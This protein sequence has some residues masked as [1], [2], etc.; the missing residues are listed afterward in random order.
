VKIIREKSIRMSCVFMLVMFM[1]VGFGLPCWWSTNSL[2]AAER[3]VSSETAATVRDINAL[4]AQLEEL[5]QLTESFAQKQKQLTA[6]NGARLDSLNRETVASSA[7]RDKDIVT[8]AQVANTKSSPGQGSPVVTEAKIEAPIVVT[9]VSNRDK[10]KSLPV[11]AGTGTVPVDPTVIPAATQGEAASVETPAIA[12]PGKAMDYWNADINKQTIEQMRE[13]QVIDALYKESKKIQMKQDRP[14]E[15]NPEVAPP[16]QTPVEILRALVKPEYLSKTMDL[17]FDETTLSDIILLVSEAAHINVVLDPAIKNDKLDLHLNKIPVEE[18]LLLLANSYNLGFKAVGDSLYITTEEKLRAQNIVSR[19]IRLKN[20]KAGE[21]KAMIKDIVPTIN[22]SDE[23][24]SVTIVGQPEDIITV[25]KIIRK[26]DRPQP[27]VVLEAR[28]IE[29]N[30]DALKDLGVAWSNK[31]NL[32]FQESGRPV[33]FANVEDAPGS[34][35]EIMAM[36][37]NPIQFSNIIQ[38]LENQNK[39]KVLSNPRVTTL[40]DKEAEIFVGDR[41]PYTVTS[42]TGGVATT[43]VRFEEPGIRLK[44]TP[45]II[46][47]DF[48]VIKVEPEVSF[49]FAFRGPDD[50]YPWTK[51]RTATAYVRVKNNQPFV[52]GGLLNEEDKRNLYKVPIL[53]DVPLLGNLFKHERQTVQESE[54]I[55]TITPTIVY[56]NP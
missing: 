26:I 42:I 44:I 41:I 11:V 31:I 20:I 50:Q 18:V 17:D 33:D 45:S 19:V 7:S 13:N 27:Q 38:M 35:F 55:I 54:L 10:E 22:L 3:P 21:V 24:N 9:P 39:A 14:Q 28:I 48:V 56:D 5:N 51:K 8:I 52:L 49:I 40:N 15:D 37:R 46:E 30:K 16:V 2:W 34:P 12:E 36:A 6:R 53:G 32:Q 47:D 25:E 4:T 23:I 29:V 43:D 1:L